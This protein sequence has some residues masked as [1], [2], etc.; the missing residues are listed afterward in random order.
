MFE[1]MEDIVP[2]RENYDV[3]SCDSKA[4]VD[5][6]VEP[7]DRYNRLLYDNDFANLQELKGFAICNLNEF[8]DDMAEFLEIDVYNYINFTCDYLL[9]YLEKDTISGE[10]KYSYFPDALQEWASVD[11]DIEKDSNQKLTDAFIKNRHKMNM[12]FPEHV[13]YDEDKMCLMVSKHCPNFGLYIFKNFKD[14]FWYGNNMDKSNDKFLTSRFIK[15]EGCSFTDSDYYIF[16]KIT[17]INTVVTLTNI[18]SRVLNTES[19]RSLLENTTEQKFKGE[20]D[21]L[22]KI[23]ADSSLTYS[24]SMVID[25]IFKEAE[26]YM[27]LQGEFNRT[28]RYVG[29]Q[30]LK[31]SEIF[32][33]SVKIMAYKRFYEYLGTAYS[34]N[35]AMIKEIK[36]R[37]RKDFGSKYPN[38]NS[39]IKDESLSKQFATIKKVNTLSGYLNSYIQKK[40][41]YHI[42]YTKRT[43]PIMGFVKA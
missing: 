21:G 25:R 26:K 29:L 7:I 23:L 14:M 17:N 28:L 41:I 6:I 11:E 20:I 2:N 12:L 19:A 43:D 40:F 34:I 30:F 33:T 13:I 4:F 24:K 37:N 35:S 36:R 1:F 38:K 10:Y 42:N 5:N 32:E 9:N 15:A 16:E 8:I 18:L 31:V 3:L 39:V 27:D 22:I